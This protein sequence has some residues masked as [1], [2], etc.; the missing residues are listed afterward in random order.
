M[1][2]SPASESIEIGNVQPT[3]DSRIIEL[4]NELETLKEDYLRARA[5]LQNNIRRSKEELN[6]ANKFAISTFAQE[7]LAVK[8]ALEMASLDESGNFENLKVGVDITLKQLSNVFERFGLR[9]INPLNQKLDPN[10]HQAISYTEDSA[11]RDTIVRV[12]QKGY[13][14]NERVLRP[15]SV[16]L[17]KGEENKGENKGQN[18]EERDPPVLNEIVREDKD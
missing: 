5:D 18:N 13:K 14:L 15:A 3:E 16:I 12:M 10:E 4:Q 2:D 1:S 17:S 6:A 7:L 8:D 9:E 11:E